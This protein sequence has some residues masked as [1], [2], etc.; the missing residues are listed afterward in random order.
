MS[1]ISRQRRAIGRT[2]LVAVLLL[3]LTLMLAA[4]GNGGGNTGAQVEGV[5]SPTAAGGGNNAA[6]TPAAGAGNGGGTTL[7][8]IKQRGTL[9]VGVKY[10]AP[11]FGSLDPK[12]NEVSGFD[13]DV[14]RAIAKH[15]LG[16]EKKVKLVQVSSKNRIPLL[17]NGQ[18][19]MF[20]ATATITPD[21]LKEI[22]FSNTYYRAGQSLLVKKDSDIKEY[23][24]LAG[25]NVCTVEGST[26]EETI[27]RLVPKAKVTL[28]E[29]YT[30]CLSSLRNGRVD[31][32]TTDNVLLEGFRQQDPENLKLT[33]G[34]FTFE[35][36]GLGIRKGNTELQ[37]AVNEALKNMQDNGE[38]AK[39]HQKWLKEPLP[40][41][42]KEW[43]GTSAQ[44]AA[45]K[46][47]EQSK[48]Q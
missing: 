34:L 43:Y 12:T 11:P 2:S 7:A 37:K 27:R 47:E 39:I 17:Q 31:A 36:Y 29:S 6:G 13:I 32:I 38:Y 25:K 33:G 30:E 16:D 1:A 3:V 10:D 23:K 45:Q 24:D 42:F 21:R 15:V 44:E 14:A 22:D 35:P 4:C 19:D 48:S 40:K 46:F 20:A 28:F 41:D 18:I 9:N 8:Q 5:V 26:P